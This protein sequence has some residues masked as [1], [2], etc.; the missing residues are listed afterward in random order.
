MDRRGKAIAVFILI[1]LSSIVAI[2]YVTPNAKAPPTNPTNEEGDSSR[3][4]ESNTPPIIVTQDVI[5]ADVGV[6]Y[7]VDYDARDPDRG[8]PVI[9]SNPDLP[10]PRAWMGCTWNGNAPYLLG[11]MEVGV[12]YSDILEWENWIGSTDVGGGKPPGRYGASAIWNGA[13]LYGI[14]GTDDGG[15]PTG[16]NIKFDPETGTTTEFPTVPGMT[17][18]HSAIF[19]GQYGYIFGGHFDI[20]PQDRIWRFDPSDES[21]TELEV[22]LPAPSSETSAVFDGR[23]A[24]IFGGYLTDEIVRFDTVSESVSVLSS[25]LPTIRVG[26]SATWDGDYAYI[27]GGHNNTTSYD[28]IVRFEPISGDVTVLSVTL[29]SG[30]WGTAA[31]SDGWSKHYIYGGTSETADLSDNVTI[32]F[33]RNTL[34]WSLSTD[35]QFLII[36]NQ[37]GILSG[38]PYL[39]DIGIFWVNVTVE[40]GNGG[41]D[42]HNFTLYVGSVNVLKKGWNLISIPLIQEEQN[43]KKVLEMIDGYYD[44]VQW[45]DITDTNDPWKH[46]KVG[47]PYGNDLSDIN[48]KM[49]FWIY[50][51]NPGDTIFLY[52]GTKP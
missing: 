32:T 34:N 6:L 37:T 29:P 52:N 35:A 36:D 38:T 43:L 51:T 22:T 25:K 3:D 4:Q 23:Y 28:E 26:T 1:L 11:G 41:M 47:K 44:I 20:L 2:S 45:Y 16:F 48:E 17:S 14:G 10:T 18:Q 12:I 30:R 31:A 50:I 21:L 39:D 9:S 42:F 8:T 49:G 5:I 24:Y 13:Y 40:D 7:E 15:A 33:P 46:H 19:T 27:F